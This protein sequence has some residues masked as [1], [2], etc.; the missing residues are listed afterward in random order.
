MQSLFYNS[1]NLLKGDNSVSSW[2]KA[3]LTLTRF[4]MRFWL[5][6]KNKN[7]NSAFLYVCSQMETVHFCMCA[8]IDAFF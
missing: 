1:K 8:H 4:Y 3:G 6:F 5:R 7:G 2:S